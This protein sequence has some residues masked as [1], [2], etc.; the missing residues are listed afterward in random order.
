MFRSI[1]YKN[2]R[3]L[4]HR[5]TRGQKSEARGQKEDSGLLQSH[6]QRLAARI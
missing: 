1:E 2:I 4:F 5:R 3:N 6:E